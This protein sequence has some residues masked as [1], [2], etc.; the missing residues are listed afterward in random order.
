M[1][2]LVIESAMINPEGKEAR[3]N[4]QVSNE[5]LN[6]EWVQIRNLSRK[7][8]PLRGVELHHW[9]YKPGAGKQPVNQRII[10]LQGSIQALSAIRI[11]SGKGKGW[12]DQRHNIVHLYINPAKLNYQ[13]QISKPDCIMIMVQGRRIDFARYD[14]PVPVGR[15]LK[16][17]ENEAAHRLEPKAVK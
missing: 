8:F 3:I 15:R 13:Y 9:V 7:T 16:R 12:L 17:T 14:P 4:A 5:L 2:I 10:R 11:H 1:A 6:E